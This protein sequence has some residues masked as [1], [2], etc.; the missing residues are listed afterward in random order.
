MDYKTNKK[1]FRNI[2]AQSF[3][4]FYVAFVLGAIFM[5]T[6]AILGL[7]VWVAGAVGVYFLVLAG[8]PSD[9]DIDRMCKE[10][11]SSIKETALNR[12]GLDPDQVSAADPIVVSGYDIDAKNSEIKYRKGKDGVYRSSQYKVT[13][14]FFSA[15]QVHSF[16]QTFSLIKD[17][18]FDS[19]DEYFYRDI[20]SVSTAQMKVEI[21]LGMN[22]QGKNVKKVHINYDYFKLMTSGG[23]SIEAAFDKSEDINRSVSAMRNLLKIKKQS[24]V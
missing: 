17:E 24:M 9:G 14:F 19:T 10:R 4:L 23:N 22:V 11:V 15:E 21:P 12:L 20:V 13:V 6:N 5:N 16:F 18:H 7:M 1:Y 2:N 8:R 3:V